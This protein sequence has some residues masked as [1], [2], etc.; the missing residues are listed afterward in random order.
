MR[1]ETD[2]ELIA[3]LIADVRKQKWMPLEEAVRQALT[4]VHGAFGIA[5]ISADEPDLLVGARKGSPLILGIGDD[6]YL[7]AS[8][9]SAV[10]ERT[11]RVTYLNDGEMVVVSVHPP[12]RPATC[13]RG[14]EPPGRTR[15]LLS[16]STLSTSGD[17]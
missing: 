16:A 8:D 2:T 15:R 14:C 3:H 5:V 1:S 17:T 12:S 10:V 9:A 7:L 4:Q 11:R 13:C 6:E